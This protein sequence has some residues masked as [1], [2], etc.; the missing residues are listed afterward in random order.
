MKY[1]NEKKGYVKRES[2]LCNKVMPLSI[3]LILAVAF[4]LTSASFL[5]AALVAFALPETKGK[6]LE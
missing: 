1:Y 5:F 6:E 4:Y 3:K 2:F